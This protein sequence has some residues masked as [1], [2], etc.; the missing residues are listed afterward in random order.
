MDKTMRRLLTLDC[1]G[2]ALGATLDSATGRTGLLIVTG[3]TQTRIGSHRLFE[4]LARAIADA[5][6]PCFRFDRRGVGDSEGVDPGWRG[7]AGDIAVA[8][9]GFRREADLDRVVGFGLC[10]GASAL[11]VHASALG[12][13]GLIL[14]NPWFVEAEAGEPPAAAVKDHYRKQLTSLAGWKKILTGSISYKKVLKGLR[15]IASP[16]PANLAEEIAR[17]LAGSF[18][19]VELILARGDATAIAAQAEWQ[20]PRFDGVRRAPPTIVES[21]SHTFARP[22]DLDALTGACLAAL[23][24]FSERA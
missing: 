8:I 17:A 13:D 11:A 20:T 3:G 5:G 24:R 23:A 18:R 10:D 6:Y 21:D 1:Q 2:C 15:K 14:V 9:A 16:P 12:L 19:P 7:S 4:R 22:V